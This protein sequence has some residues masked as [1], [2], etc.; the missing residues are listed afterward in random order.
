MIP[1]RAHRPLIFKCIRS[2]C[3][4]SSEKYISKHSSRILSAFSMLTSSSVLPS[5]LS[6]ALEELLFFLE[7]STLLDRVTDESSSPEDIAGEKNELPL[8]LG[9]NTLSDGAG[10]ESSS[11]KGVGKKGKLHCLSEVSALLNGVVNDVNLGFKNELRFPLGVSSLLDEVVKGSS[12]P[13]DDGGQKDGLRLLSGVISFLDGFMNKSSRP[14]R[15]VCGMRMISLRDLNT[16]G[17][18]DE[19]LL[20][21]AR[22][23]HRLAT[24]N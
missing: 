8:T 2:G 24:G 20:S 6:S 16:N 14:K 9:S 13:E 22:E 3:L 7:A 15:C 21:V 4:L 18:H 10:N 5:P 23:Q 17:V 1:L 19:I 12:L 11:E